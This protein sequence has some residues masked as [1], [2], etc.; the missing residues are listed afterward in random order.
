MPIY[1]YRCGQFE[2][3]FEMRLSFQEKERGQKPDCPSC[4]STDTQQLI[5]GGMFI[6]SG[7]RSDNRGSLPV[8]GPNADRGCCG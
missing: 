6:R 1:D 3:T 8:C 7:Q 2:T 4:S 5:S